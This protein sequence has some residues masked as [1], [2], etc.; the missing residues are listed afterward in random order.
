M[1]RL[2]PGVSLEKARAQLKVVSPQIVL[3]ALPADWDRTNQQSFKRIQVVARPAPNG[4]SFLRLRFTNPLAILMTLV[5]IVLLIACSN[6]ANLMFARSSARQREIAVRLAMGAGRSR[7]IRQLLTESILLA[8]LGGVSG[9]AFAFASTRVLVSILTANA[10]VGG[11]G[12]DIHLDFHP[13]WRIL[14]F[15]FLAALL[16]GLLFGLAPALRAT[17][18]AIIGSRNEPIPCTEPVP[19]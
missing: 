12:Q 2:A 18:L 5:G 1:G 9:L 3:D 10:S 16:S 19:E 15:T 6:L 11:P 7:V 4:W 14:L 8:L 13:D 17:R